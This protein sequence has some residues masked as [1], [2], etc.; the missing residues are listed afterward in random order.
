[1]ALA[2]LIIGITLVMEDHVFRGALCI[3]IAATMT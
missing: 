2:L 3:L 1:M